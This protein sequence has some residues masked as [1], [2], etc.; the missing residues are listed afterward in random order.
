M[1][2]YV[3]MHADLLLY[4]VA[5]TYVYLQLKKWGSRPKP[6]QPPLLLRPYRL[7]THASSIISCAIRHFF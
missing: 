3:N 5:Y 7:L 4:C 1:C 2:L 6:P